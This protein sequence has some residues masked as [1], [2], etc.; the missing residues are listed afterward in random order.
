MLFLNLD[1]IGA[2][3]FRSELQNVSL[4]T[5]PGGLSAFVMAAEVIYF[6]FIL[7]YMFLQVSINHLNGMPIL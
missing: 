2:F 4:Y 6:L 3:Q 5:A 1:Y 7:Y